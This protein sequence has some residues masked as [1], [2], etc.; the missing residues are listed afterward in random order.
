MYAGGG[1]LGD[2]IAYEMSDDGD[3]TW[4]VTVSLLEGTSGNYIFLNSPVNA[5]DWGAKEYLIDECSDTNN[6]ND[7]ILAEV[8]AD[9]ILLHC[10]GSCE[11]D[12]TCG[13][14]AETV[15]MPI[16]HE[17]ENVVYAWN[18]FGGAA[19]TV[20]ANPDASGVNTSATVAKSVKTAGS[21]TWAG[22][23]IVLD[24]L[25]D[26]STVTTLAVDVWTPDG[27][28]LVNLKVK[29]D[30]ES[31]AIEIIQP[32]TVASGWETLYYDLS[33]YDL[34]VDYDKLELVFDFDVAGDDTAYYFD[35]IRLAFRPN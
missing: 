19:T 31:Y 10:F 9:T 26:F 3:G 28:E 22:T 15:L 27:G 24:E 14:P 34:S 8:T 33:D 7:R 21:E 17:N 5:G 6:Y 16:D 12:G 11:T 1:I 20:I 25:L 35:N 4:T 18:D 2:A 23:F 30:G 32:T 29:K 13:A